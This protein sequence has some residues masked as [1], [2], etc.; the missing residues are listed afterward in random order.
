MIA[1]MI[2]W[3]ILREIY[4]RFMGTRAPFNK[5]HIV[6]RTFQWSLENIMYFDGIIQPVPLWDFPF[7]LVFL[8]AIYLSPLAML[9][10][11]SDQYI[12]L[13]TYI[14]K[15]NFKPE[16]AI[17]FGGWGSGLIVSI[18]CYF[19]LSIGMLRSRREHSY[20]TAY[21]CHTK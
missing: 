8:K 7:Y 1:F 9:L 4:C 18:L 2:E 6:V 3:L 5:G 10:C 16:M 15:S 14:L 20:L 21:T 11:L 19:G 13:I 17:S 12:V